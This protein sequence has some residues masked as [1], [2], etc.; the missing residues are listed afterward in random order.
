MD[1]IQIPSGAPTSDELQDLA[2][3]AKTAHG[4]LKRDGTEVSLPI[5]VEFAG[6]PKSG[7]STIIGIVAHFLR[8][9]GYRVG[10]PPE[11]AS[12]RTP[13]DLKDDLLAFN[14]WSACYALQH[15]LQDA[16]AGD[17]EDIVILDRGVF[18]AVVWMRFLESH[19]G[20]LAK[21]DREVIERF[22]LLDFWARREAAVFLFT[23]NAETSM[24]REKESKLTQSM[25]RAMN[26]AFLSSLRDVYLSTARDIGDSFPRVYH[27]D[28]SAAG[29]QS[30]SF[31]RVAALVAEE[32]VGMIQKMAAPE[33]MVTKPFDQT[34]F[35][36]ERV[37][38]AIESV[39][40][41]LT[42]MD[43]AVAE[44]STDV[45]QIV[46]YSLLK[47]SEDKYLCLRRKSD[48][49]RSELA[50]KWTLLV[51]GHAERRDWDNGNRRA[52]FETCVRREVT[53]ELIGLELSEVR[54][55]GLLN[56]DR[57]SMGQ[58]H[59]AVIHESKVGGT[60]AVRRQTVDKEFG[61]ER[62]VWKSASEC[63]E[64]VSDLDPWSQLVAEKQFGAVL[65]PEA[66]LGNL[67][68]SG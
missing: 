23:A 1:S 51:G 31:Q 54:L 3:R 10:Q 42:P 46:P 5:F 9:M 58:K 11:G 53:E 61:R 25:G 2:E 7:K 52:V 12:L 47:N 28:T 16:H 57:N 50:G 19:H 8:R 60:A 34:G 45:Q 40:A 36:T 29:S 38:Q 64:M 13:P 68:T 65:P 22:L 56:D 33:I 48:N 55:L 67:F 17:P 18:D 41:D 24:Q 15:V 37:E 20:R 63:A 49:Q 44:R 43:R 21:K 62:A 32:V 59:L 4:A 6:S 14:A 26:P 35:I 30:P 66:R 39:L 27:L